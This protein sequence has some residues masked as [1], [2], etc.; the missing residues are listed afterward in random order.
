MIKAIIFDWGGVLIE[1]T[2][3]KLVKDASKTINVPI[4][5]VR[6]VLTKYDY[7]FCRN[8]ITEH[9]IWEELGYNL[10]SN[11]LWKKIFEQHYTPKRKVFNIAEKLKENGYFISLLSNTELPCVDIYN[12]RHLN[13]FD[14]A[15]FSCLEGI[16]KPDPEIYKIAL[17]KLN[18]EPK[19][20]VFIDD[21]IK[22]IRGAQN[23]GIYTI[24]YQNTKQLERD[25]YS[26]NIK[27]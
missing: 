25:L 9:Q 7:P 1:N 10:N 13:F 23:I 2:R 16:T 11:S 24:L 22:N 21:Q 17:N 3:E 8:K 5:R 12:E 14:A 18:L 15:T 4:D 27:Y 26:I 19:Q 6:S 20:A